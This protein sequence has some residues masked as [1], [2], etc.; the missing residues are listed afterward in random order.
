VETTNFNDK[1]RFRNLPQTNM[2]VIER[3]TGA[4]IRRGELP[5]TAEI[6]A[7]EREILEEELER[8]LKNGQ[9]GQFREVVEELADEHDVVDIAAAA[10]AL[11]AKRS[12]RPAAKS[13][14]D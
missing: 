4:R 14:A 8:M 12:G 11:V 13:R 7:R 6:A 9:W 5:T 10:I 3:F 1:Q 2:K